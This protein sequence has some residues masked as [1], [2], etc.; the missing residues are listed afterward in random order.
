MTVPAAPQPVLPG[1]FFFERGY[2]NGNHLAATGDA[3]VLVD[4]GYA[5]GLP[6]TLA[7]LAAVG[8][9]PG[10]VAT[11]INTHLHCDHIGGNA[12]LLQAGQGGAWLH[13]AARA[14]VENRDRRATWWDYYGQEG[15]FFPVEHWLEDGEEVQ[16]GA[17]RFQVLHVPGHAADLI[18]LYQPEARLLLSSD[19]LW[20]RS[21]AVVTPEIEGDDAPQRWLHSLERLANLRVERV[22]PGHGAPF[23][24][25]FGALAQTRRQLE[26]YC[27]EPRA[28]AVELLRKIVVYTLLMRGPRPAEGFFDE[29]LETP[30]FPATVRRWFDGAYRAA[31]DETLAYL[32]HRRLVVREGEQLRTTVRP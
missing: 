2:L 30:W 32:L 31:Y 12:A 23:C 15:E 7:H 25:F 16:L 17:H 5:A 20:E 9:A 21:L 1:L 24:D 27:A 22:Y 26:R 29:L 13:G 8:I 14:A 28:L 11:I 3:P 10:S 4:T 18:A 6:A 19:A